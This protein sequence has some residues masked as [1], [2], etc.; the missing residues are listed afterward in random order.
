MHLIAYSTVQD[1]RGGSHGH[2]S[3]V[4][5]SGCECGELNSYSTLLMWLFAL[6]LPG[7]ISRHL[8]IYVCSNMRVPCQTTRSEDKDR[9][10]GQMAVYK[11][12]CHVSFQY[13][14]QMVRLSGRRFYW[15]TH[16]YETCLLSILGVLVK[17]SIAVMKHQDVE[18][19][20]ALRV[21]STRHSTFE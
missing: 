17:V 2:L 12:F 13:R 5:L 14:T 18:H 21:A 11:S 1:R 3:V 6:N 4:W 19:P 15:L 20:C 7:F 16:L 9:W 8:L 10:Q